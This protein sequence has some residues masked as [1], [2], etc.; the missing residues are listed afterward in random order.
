MK[1]HKN[2]RDFECPLQT[3]FITDHLSR[4]WLAQL[5]GT[6]DASNCRHVVIKTRADTAVTSTNDESSYAE[7]RL[8]LISS[9]SVFV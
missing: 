5:G 2:E 3:I 8:L 4:A 9:L 6:G 1:C 7:D